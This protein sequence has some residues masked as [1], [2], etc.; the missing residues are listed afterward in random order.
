MTSRSTSLEL[1]R[2]P[3]DRTGDSGEYEGVDEENTQDHTGYPR[4]FQLE[5]AENPVRRT[6]K[7]HGERILRVHPR[8]R[9]HEPGGKANSDGDLHAHSLA[10]RACRRIPP[11]ISSCPLRHFVRH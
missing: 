3:D 5:H 6:E 2:R 7:H 11:H 4:V 8:S 1:P 9:E 10:P